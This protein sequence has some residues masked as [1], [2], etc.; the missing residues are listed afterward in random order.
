MM[1]I[2]TQFARTGN[3]RV[4]GLIEWPAWNKESDQYLLI[5]DGLQV[6]SGYSDLTKIKPIK[7]SFS[8]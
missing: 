1:N 5:S 4:K 7:S 6:K 3:P 8:L 2:W